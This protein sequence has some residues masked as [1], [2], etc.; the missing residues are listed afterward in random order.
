MASQGVSSSMDLTTKYSMPAA[1]I[2]REKLKTIS[3][4]IIKF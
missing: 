2:Y 4:V 3:Q 1:I